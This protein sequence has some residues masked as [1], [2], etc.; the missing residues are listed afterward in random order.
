MDSFRYERKFRIEHLNKHEIEQTIK[1]HSSLFLEIFYERQVNNI[2]LDTNNL[3]SYFDNLSGISERVKIRIRW[4]GSLTKKINNPILEIKIKNNLLGKKIRYPLKPFTLN[5]DFSVKELHKIFSQSNLPKPLK[6]ILKTLTPSLL[7]SYSRKY[8]ISQ[9]KK[10][11]LTIDSKMNFFNLNKTNNT[12]L[13]KYQDTA[14]I[15]ELKYSSENDSNAQTISNK[16]PFRLTKNSKY[17]TGI[18]LLHHN[19]ILN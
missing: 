1:S 16:F 12:F 11:R 4:Y 19:E 8:F 9:G 5:K 7:N 10:Y 18:N 17:I 6:E 15:L 14:N 2:Y 13:R 3:K